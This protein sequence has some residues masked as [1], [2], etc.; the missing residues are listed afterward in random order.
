MWCVIVTSRRTGEILR[1]E[2]FDSKTA[3]EIRKVQIGFLPVPPQDQWNV[4]VEMI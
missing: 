2:Y 1:R 3:A 4:A